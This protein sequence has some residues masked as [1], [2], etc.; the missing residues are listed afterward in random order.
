MRFGVLSTADI[1][2]NAVIP[3]IQASEH[4]VAA[5]AS[6]DD[7]RAR[8]VADE[9]GIERSYGRYED[10]LADDSLD[11]V[12]IP[13]PN[14]LHAEWIRKAAD[15]GLHVLCEKP[16]TGSAEETA[17]V[18]DYCA[19]RDVV[20]MEAFMYRFHPRTERA[21]EIVDE[22]LGDVVSMTASFSF[23]MPAGAEDI[24]LDPELE[25]GS[26]MDV[27]CYTVSATRLFLGTPDRVY[28][29]TK[30]TRNSGVDTRMAAVL[31]YD[32]GPVARLESSF[33]TPKTQYYRI[34]T[35]DGWLKAEPTFAVDR[36][37]RVEL[38]Y[39]AD[40]REVT[41]TFDPVDDYRSEVEHFADCVSSGETPRVD[42]TESV[43]VMR[44]ID[45]LYESAER[46]ESVTID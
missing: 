35:T 45:A 24:R 40:G 34:Q 25:G 44:I 3:A 8:T 7:S 10:L 26:I 13:L 29:T 37:E 38:T 16:L 12:Y 18:F 46:G 11:A 23:R 4:T 2:V 28:A 19:E 5:I 33:D 17:A 15:A 27:G 20:L 31:T 36:S 9:C 22:E 32:S 14:G 42:R 39:T 43:A 1:G 41:E 6:R 21:K 30:D